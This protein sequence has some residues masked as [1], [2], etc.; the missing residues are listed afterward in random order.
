[1]F[2]SSL[3]DWIGI[4]KTV[5]HAVLTPLCSVLDALSLVAAHGGYI[6][7]RLSSG[8]PLCARFDL[9]AAREIQVQ[10]FHVP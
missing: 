7:I 6:L 8:D 9:S 2:L 4:S 10:D 3:P 5:R 1:M